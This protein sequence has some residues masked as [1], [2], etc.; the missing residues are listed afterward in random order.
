[1]VNI[2]EARQRAVEFITEDYGLDET[3]EFELQR[4]QRRQGQWELEFLVVEY[5]RTA[6]FNRRQRLREVSVLVVLD[7]SDG[8]VTYCGDPDDW[9]DDDIED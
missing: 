3:Y 1:M 9:I 2:R 7:A 5:G 4:Q 8:E 6:L